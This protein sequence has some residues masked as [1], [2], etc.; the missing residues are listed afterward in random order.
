MAKVAKLKIIGQAAPIEFPAHLGDSGRTL[1]REVQE[2]Y[3]IEDAGGRQLLLTACEATDRAWRARKL[4]EQH[5]EVVLTERGSMRANPAC[6][7]E[8]DAWAAQ[9]H[10]LRALNLD[11][12][13]LRDAPGRPPGLQRG[14]G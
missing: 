1:W 3:R 9:R 2:Q 13:A 10:A 5:G 6:Q 4:I 7:I 11:T 8:R 14:R 12:E